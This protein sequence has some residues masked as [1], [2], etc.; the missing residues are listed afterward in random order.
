MAGRMKLLQLLKLSHAEFVTRRKTILLSVLAAGIPFIIILGVSFLANG[1]ENVIMEYMARPTDGEVYLVLEANEGADVMRGVAENRGEIIGK[2][3]LEGAKKYATPTEMLAA[4]AKISP[5]KLALSPGAEFL[6]EEDKFNILD[7]FFTDVTTYRPPFQDQ[8]DML[9]MTLA[10][11]KQLAFAKFPT[12]EDA[13]SYYNEVIAHSRTRNC[14]EA[15]TSQLRTYAN[16]RSSW[17]TRKNL[18]M[19]I[20]V[21]AAIIVIGTYVYLLDQELH[22]MVV[23]QALGASK[24]DLIVISL[25]YLLEI[26]IATV[27]YAVLGGT[28]AALVVS[29]VNA[30][31][32]G[33]M[34][35]KLFNIESAKVMFMGWGV[36]VL[37]VVLTVMAMAPVSLLLTIDQFS[38]KRLSQKLKRD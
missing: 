17:R 28:I 1:I 26:G 13:Y 9:E 4:M 2:I 10:Q 31:Y 25:G 7:L 15:F 5:E 37:W 6:D 22:T 36:E 32:A 30:G 3:T 14:D 8:M 18:M 24:K 16:F 21:V 20:L 33:E 23:Y 38:T 35:T 34:I 27:A 12:V 29:G 11:E 19:V